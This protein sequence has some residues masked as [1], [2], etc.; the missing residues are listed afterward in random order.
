MRARRLY[1]IEL[2]VVYWLLTIV[3]AKHTNPLLA[4]YQRTTVRLRDLCD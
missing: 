1:K 2:A 4:R 3:P